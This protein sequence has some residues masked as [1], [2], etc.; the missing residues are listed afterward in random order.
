M[1]RLNIL[2][3]KNW[4]LA[5]FNVVQLGV[6]HIRCAAIKEKL[7]SIA[8]GIAKA[9]LEAVRVA[10]CHSNIHLS[11]TYQ[12]MAN[13]VGRVSHSGEE[14]LQLKKYIQKCLTDQEKLKEEMSGNMEKE[15]FLMNYR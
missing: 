9:L 2:L 8:E 3:K 7:A 10:V 14:V 1:Q 6:Y 15:N 5:L 13:Q 4:C 11:E 12:D